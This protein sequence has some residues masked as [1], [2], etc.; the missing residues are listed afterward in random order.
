MIYIGKSVPP[1]CRVCGKQQTE[2]KV[3]DDYVMSSED[4]AVSAAHAPYLYAREVSLSGDMAAAEELLTRALKYKPDFEDAYHNRSEARIAQ[5]NLKG[6]ME[7]CSKVIALNPKAADAYLTRSA[8]KAGLEDYAGGA[9]DA[10]MALK[11]GITL[12]IAYYNRGICRLFIGEVESGRKDL[13]RF[14]ELAPNDER[15][16]SVRNILHMK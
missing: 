1:A 12:P 4:R 3:P 9:A 8:A 15:A 14:L 16:P 5:G 13:E 6:G 7:D 11:L 2:I 10:D